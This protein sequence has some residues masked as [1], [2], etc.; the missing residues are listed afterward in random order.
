MFGYTKCSHKF[1]LKSL[2]LTVVLL[3]SGVSVYAWDRNPL[4]QTYNIYNGLSDDTVNDILCDKKGFVWLATHKGLDRYDGYH[5]RH[6]PVN[7]PRSLCEDA[8]GN[9]WLGTYDGV[10]KYDVATEKISQVDMP[11]FMHESLQY[12]VSSYKDKVI[13]QC[14][15]EYCLQFDAKSQE[16]LDVLQALA[17]TVSETG[18]LYYISPEGALMVSAEEQHANTVLTS[19][20]N[21]EFIEVSRLYKVGD[22]LYLCTDQQRSYVFNLISRSVSVSDRKVY[23]VLRRSNGEVWI[24]YVG[25]ISVVDN[26][27]QEIGSYYSDHRSEFHL[28]E[29]IRT[30]YE[31]YQGGVWAGTYYSG[32]IHL[33]DNLAEVK[34][35]VPSFA[36]QHFWPRNIVESRDGYLWV[37]T[38]ST[39][40]Y[41][42]DP[43]T[44]SFV[45]THLPEE[46]GLNEHISAAAIVGDELLLGNRVGTFL[47]DY[48]TGRVRP[49]ASGMGGSRAFLLDNDGVL[50]VSFDNGIYRRDKDGSF[51]Q[52]C[53]DSYSSIIKDREGRVWATSFFYGVLKYTQEG[54]VQ[55]YNVSNGKSCSQKIS[56]IV[57]DEFGKIWA[58]TYGN[59]LLLYSEKEDRFISASDLGAPML[60]VFKILPDADGKFWITMSQSMIL[61]DPVTRKS[62]S[63]SQFD[64]LPISSFNYAAGILASDGKLYF[65]SRDMV[66]SFSPSYKELTPKHIRPLFVAFRPLGGAGYRT[67]SQNF[68]SVS[69]AHLDLANGCNSFEFE[70]S[71]MNYSLPRNSYLYYRLEGLSSK[72][73]PVEDGRISFINLPVGKYTLTIRAQNV[74]GVFYPTENSVTFRVRPPFM[75]SVFMIVLYVLVLGVAVYCI[76]AYYKRKALRDARVKAMTESLIRESETEKKL[77]ASK[78]EF[79]TNIAHEIKTP[80]SLIKLPAESLARKFRSFSDKSVVEDVEI[81]Y[82]NSEKLNHLLVEL[83]NIREFDSVNYNLNVEECNVS[84]AISGVFQRFE[85]A[86]RKAGVKFTLEMEEDQLKTSLDRMHFDKVLTNMFS[87]AIKYSDSWVAVK[88]SKTESSFTVVVENDGTIVPLDMRE[89]IFHPLVRYVSGNLNVPGTGLGLSISRKLAV[90][91]GGNLY[92]DEELSVN[93]FIFAMPLVYVPPQMD[94]VRNSQQEEIEMISERKTIMVVEDNDDMADYIARKFRSLYKVVRLEDGKGALDY[95]GTGK[96][97]SV[98]ITDLMMPNMD[99]FELCKEIKKNKK[100]MNIP[101]VVV[102]AMPEKDAK[103]QSL[104]NGADAYLE[105]PFTFELLQTT[106][107]GLLT[108]KERI[109]S[110]YSSYPIIG[111]DSVRLSAPD[112]RFLQKIQEHIMANLSN[113]ALRVDDLAVVANMSKSNLLKKMKTLV[114]MTPAEYILKIR[115]KKS[116]EL[117]LSGEY[118]VSEISSMV[119]FSSPSYFSQA[120]TRE[121][122]V[123]PKQYRENMQ[124]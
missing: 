6:V 48:R 123:Y 75:L 117:L 47:Y 50:W 115:L 66:L 68:W 92:M 28:P 72:W 104:E 45:K 21:E 32:V 37:S 106:L 82:K 109:Q 90:L 81:I 43:R 120:F 122:A 24:S 88:V 17:S 19:E 30:L 65:G 61:F 96:L 107:N 99:G 22:Y 35:Y 100:T 102:S 2:I 3:L 25:G 77:Y 4:V 85:G 83:L 58:G 98:I 93:R 119:G 31:D 57:Q 29:S 86:A 97:P 64:G 40:L 110:Y 118:S 52:I 15:A 103:I 95:L 111:I 20:R 76:V 27:Q 67:S 62:V 91:M 1:Y 26:N 60:P 101:I 70:V 84:K 113:T 7:D 8:D 49:L 23:D 114:K 59:G 105:K 116:Q 108:N 121:Y 18:E 12:L 53:D 39:G 80:L 51:H 33:V 55:C 42:L 78:I 69:D 44:G 112:M 89:K 74:S 16:C 46:T 71:D 36:E 11:S 63:Y 56:S 87:N 14:G 41:K 13:V 9:I 54:G 94:V 10:Y 79:I 73:I 124:K 5:I 38:S 34:T